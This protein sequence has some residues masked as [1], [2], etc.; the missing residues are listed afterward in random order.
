MDI[1]ASVP[2][3]TWI[4][5]TLIMAS[6][7]ALQAAF[8]MGIA[9]FTIPLLA[10]IDA[11]L[12]PG[13]MLLASIGLSTAMAFEGRAKIRAIEIGLAT[14]GLVIGTVIGTVALLV[15]SSSAL[16]R[17]LGGMII[18]AVII[19]AVGVRL[20]STPRALLGGGTAG[21]L[22]GVIA[23]VHGPPMALVFQN[24]EPKRARAMLAA[25]FSLACPLA[26]A[27]MALAGLFG[28]REFVLGLA[29]IPGIAIGYALAPLVAHRVD[30]A[31][32]RIAI[33]TISAVSGIVLLLR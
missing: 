33:L 16:P 23:G 29:L 21:G 4:L 1:L 25:Y 28:V 11:R 6:G 9:L 15:T 2:A 18:L 3:T 31:I 30:R 8:G 12:V 5:A 17:L 24:D 10:L 14:I 26:L 19:S 22:M 13:P 20:A 7:A 32:L 27:G